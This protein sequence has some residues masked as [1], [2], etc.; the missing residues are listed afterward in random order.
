MFVDSTEL[1]VIKNLCECMYDFKEILIKHYSDLVKS[2]NDV[3][4][5]EGLIS[6]C[7]DFIDAYKIFMS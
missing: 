5:Y 2:E 6:L 3:E 4:Y 1:Q 7:N